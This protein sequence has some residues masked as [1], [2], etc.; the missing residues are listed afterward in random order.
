MGG[1]S[2]RRRGPN[3][4]LVLLGAAALAV[5]V[6]SCSGSGGDDGRAGGGD[7]AAP[8]S[9]VSPVAAPAP[10]D[11]L[12]L[13]PLSVAGGRIVDDL[14]RDVLLRGANV[15][16]LGEYHRA[17][18]VVAPTAPVTDDDWDAMAAHGLSV[19]RLIISWSRVEP[20]RG[21]VDQEYLAEVG[22]A[23]RA[24]NAR[25]IYVVLDMHQDAWSA[26]LA[27]PAGET[28]PEGTEPAIGWDGAPAWAT[29][30]DGQS[31]C[32]P[33]SRESAP[34]VQAAFRNFYADTDG[35]RSRLAATWGRIAA[36]FA[37]TPGIA[38][39][40]LLNEPNPVQPGPGSLAGYSRFV[41][42]AIAAIRAAEAGAGADPTP[43]F[44]EPIVS[45]PL[46][47]S[48]PDA[49]VVSDPDLVFAPH[50]YAESIGP[51]ILTLEQTFAVD[52]NGADQLGPPGD[53][54]A[55]WIGEYGWWDTGAESL[56]EARRY[57][58]EE[59]RRALGGAW[60]QWRQTC[61]DPHSVG[62]PGATATEDQVH[63]VRR[64]CPGDT[65]AGLTEEFLSI[66]G[67]AYPRAAPGR[68]A[69][70]ISD[71]ATGALTVRGTGAGPG[72]EL[73]VWLPD[74]DGAPPVEPTTVDGLGEVE[75]ERVRG[76]RLLTATT[77]GADYILVVS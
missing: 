31:T 64:T 56:E 55:L 74:V 46:S 43:V 7:A 20:V 34:A 10:G 22:D 30:T 15:N 45:Y 11:A 57:A 75:I 47:D 70:L 26:T 5:G 14:G 69:E 76:G 24:A 58:A 25:G 61:G 32:R 48:M 35:I 6:A 3:P 40:E 17:D 13:R 72:V 36:F 51:E 2:R 27:T 19:A 29:I 52:Q 63:L 39:Y 65:D 12:E 44:V 60:W 49:A 8:T 54:A 1:R 21:E 4:A 71:P 18:P 53:P 38:G 66:L 77:T 59:D 28:C 50:N 62:S 33:G 23:V 37:G 41:A 16:A 73:V 9:G 68:I 67:R 42:D